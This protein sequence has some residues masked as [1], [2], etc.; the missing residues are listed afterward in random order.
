MLVLGARGPYQEAGGDETLTK[1]DSLVSSHIACVTPRP[2]QKHQ[3][4]A[5]DR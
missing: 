5:Q 4:L 1:A 3:E 2:V